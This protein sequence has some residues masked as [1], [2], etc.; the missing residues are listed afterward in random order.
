MYRSDKKVQILS[1]SESFVS[2]SHLFQGLS[3]STNMFVVPISPISENADS[4]DTGEA[5]ATPVDMFVQNTHFGQKPQTIR[6]V[7]IIIII[8]HVI[9]VIN[10]YV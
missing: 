6:K 10:N 2:A 5:K 9:I 1:P 8:M 7:N 3:T 4:T